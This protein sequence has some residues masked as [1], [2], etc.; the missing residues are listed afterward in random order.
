MVGAEAHACPDLLYNGGQVL[1]NVRGVRVVA[2]MQPR[3]LANSLPLP[4]TPL[5]G[6][7]G[8]V[9][10]VREL[11]LRSDLRRLTLT[12]PGGAGKTRLALEIAAS[13]AHVFPDGVRFVDLA[14]IA[15]RLCTYLHQKRLLLVFDNFE[16]VVEAAPL[17]PR[18]L[19]RCPQLNILVTS[20]M[21]LPVSGERQNT[22]APLE[23]AATAGPQHVEEIARSPAVRL[24]VERAQAVSEEFAL[25]QE[26]APVVAEICRW[27]D[28]LPLA[29]EQAAARIK[30]LPPAALLTRMEQRLPVLSGGN[31]ERTETVAN[32]RQ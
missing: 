23:I 8:E 3:D 19:G 6:R 4:L 16:Q 9:A 30:I 21:R 25:I 11:L 24:V 2:A 18:P 17:L 29:I 1:R 31:R 15:D 5:I 10:A 27:V 20:R 14:P 22:V 28:G 32:H 13:V 7:E 12:G 26:N